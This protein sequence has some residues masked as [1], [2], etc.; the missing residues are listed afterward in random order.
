MTH[1]PIPP[2]LPP[3]QLAASIQRSRAQTPRPPHTMPTP[4]A[5][6]RTLCSGL[7]LLGLMAVL[8][9]L[10]AR[11]DDTQTELIQKLATR[12]GQLEQQL[13]DLKAGAPAVTEAAVEEAQP[14]YPRVHLNGF[15]DFTYRSSSAAGTHNEFEIGEF[16]FFIKAAISEKANFLAETV[17]SADGTNN[18]GVDIERILF[19]YRLNPYFNVAV[20]RYHT[21]IGYYNNAFHHGTWFQTAT[22][23]PSFL[24][25]EDS[26]GL[27]PVHNIGLTANG[28]IPS[29]TLG[30]HYNVEIGNGRAYGAP[31]AGNNEVQNVVDNNDHKAVN[32]VL[33]ARPEGIAGL[34]TGTGLYLDQLSPAGQVKTK[35]VIW[36]S[37]LLYKNARWEF[38]SENYL[39]THAPDGS[40]TTRS[41]L[42]FAQLARQFGPL[43]PYVRYT[44]TDVPAN[45]HAYALLGFTGRRDEN[46]LGVRWDFETYAAIK[47]QYDIVKTRGQGN[48]DNFSLQLALTF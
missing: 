38:L 25:F 13:K 46:S 40:A 15:A 14:S 2:A 3:Y 27:L 4:P 23:R 34:Q 24:E 35:E 41:S 8:P 16:D 6:S 21:A 37:F 7:I 31:A 18:F 43:R 10:M 22:G 12:V 28:E 5:C 45:D 44:H 47:A 19:E 1:R 9:G 39:V 36:H 20:G 42:W 32:F 33:A 11:A 26:G 17:I 30:L 48:E 29:G